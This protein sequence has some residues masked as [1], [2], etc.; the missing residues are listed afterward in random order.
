MKWFGKAKSDEPRPAG[1]KADVTPCARPPRRHRRWLTVL[2]VM[3]VVAVLVG[4]TFLTPAWGLDRLR[5]SRLPGLYAVWLPLLFLMLYAL[6]WLCWWAVRQL[7]PDHLTGEYP[8]LERAWASARQALDAQGIDLRATPLFLVLG[9]PA[10]GIDLFFSASRW[11]FQVRFRSG[12][13]EPLVALCANREAAFLACPAESLLAT[14]A[15]SPTA[16]E[17]SAQE[18]AVAEPG[19]V[20]ELGRAE[21]VAAVGVLEE[22]PCTPQACLLCEG[23]AA[24]PCAPR[25]TPIRDRRLVEQ[26]SA[27]LR[28]LCRL[29]AYDRQ[30]YVPINGV[31]A[32]FPLSATDSP[33][34]MRNAAAACRAD[35]QAV[36]ETAGLECPHLALLCDMQRVPGFAELLAAFPDRPTQQWVLGRTFPLVPDIAPERWPG[37]IEQGV[38]WLSDSQWPATIYPILRTDTADRQAEGLVLESNQRCFRL[39]EEGRR[40]LQLVP[41]LLVRSFQVSPPAR[42]L[43]AGFALAGTGVDGHQEQ[44]FVAGVLRWMVEA[45]DHVAWTSEAL[46]DEATCRFWTRLGFYGLAAFL[47]LLGVLSVGLMR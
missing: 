4:L 35:L 38:R 24:E 5:Q 27:R 42:P 21:A 33:E 26:L 17:V 39:L 36:R 22:A 8:D 14:L 12:E 45:Q 10:G 13:P 29:V 30:P 34:W 23:E 3:A 46:R 47:C 31:L 19:A 6:C 2:H 37:M 44:G 20:A 40:R 9:Q 28:Y 7:G 15:L 18:V 1:A 25:A 16:G 32:L 11:P 41:E 43:F